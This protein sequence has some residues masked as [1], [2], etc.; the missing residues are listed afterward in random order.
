MARSASATAI[1]PAMVLSHK[2]PEVASAYDER[3]PSPRICSMERPNGCS[4][5]DVA[6]YALGVGAC[7]ADAADEKELQLVYH[8]DGQSSIKVLPTFISVLNAKT[9]DGFYM[10]VPGLHYDPALLLHG[11]QYIEIYR[12]IPSRANVANKIKIAGLHDRGKAAILEVETLTCLEGSGE[13]LCMN[14]STIYLRG[15]GGFSNSSQPF[16]YATYPSNEVSDVT[17]P[18]ST[19]FAVCEDRTQKSQALLCGLSGYFHPLHSDPI[20]AQA[21]G[22]TRPIMPGLSTLGFA[23]RAIMRSF[24]D[25]EPTAVKAISC[26]F[27]HHVYPGETLVTEMWLEGQRVYYRTK[28]KERGRAVL[29]GYV[30]LQN[31]PSPLRRQYPCHVAMKFFGIACLMSIVVSDV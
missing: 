6:L 1:D 8:R 13:V 11:Q 31:V 29:S 30:L 16:S 24:C 25:M 10:D 3:S 4:E 15:A 7:N 12:P 26:R 14:R 23:V 5:W 19:P 2:F 18:D 21:A 27:L 22:F 20:F 9:G 28:V 17:F